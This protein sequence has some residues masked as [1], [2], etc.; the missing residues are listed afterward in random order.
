[1]A[2]VKQPLF[3]QEAVGALGGIQFRRGT[4]GPIVSRRSVTPHLMTPAQTLQRSRL[5]HAH[6]AFDA[7]TDAQ[8]EAWNAFATY[9]ETGRNAYVRAYTILDKLGLTP[10]TDPRT[11]TDIPRI[12]NV[13]AAWY[14]PTAKRLMVTWTLDNAGSGR[15]LLYIYQTWS[16][17]DYPKPAKLIYK[18]NGFDYTPYIIHTLPYL[19]PRT[20]LRLEL[21]S[22]YTGEL[23]SSHLMHLDLP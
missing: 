8:R 6:R 13:T 14:P 19:S 5:A 11:S 16:N 7:L 23:Y 20:W 9:P 18:A 15:L 2:K 4:Y 17:R 12:S 22:M 1:M 10:A 21:R 3:S